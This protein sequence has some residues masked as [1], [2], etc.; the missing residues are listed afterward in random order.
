MSWKCL[1]V[2]PTPKLQYRWYLNILCLYIWTHRAGNSCLTAAEHSSLVIYGIFVQTLCGCIFR[3]R[4]S[5]HSFSLVR[6]PACYWLSSVLIN[7]HKC[8]RVFVRLWAAAFVWL[9]I[10]LRFYVIVCFRAYAGGYIVC[11]CLF[12]HWYGLLPC[13][14]LNY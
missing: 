11:V 4:G 8:I 12:G 1:D 3:L 7:T 14:L 6:M 13:H 5:A 9:S 10:Q 2:L